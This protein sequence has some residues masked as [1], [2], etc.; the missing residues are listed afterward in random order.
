MKTVEII[1]SFEGYPEGRK[2]VFAIGETPSLPDEF[3]DLI[4]EKRHARAPA[5]EPAA[6]PRKGTDK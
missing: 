2:V 6:K 1:E 3:A 5:A 4:I